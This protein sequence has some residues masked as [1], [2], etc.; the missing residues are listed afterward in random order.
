[1]LEAGLDANIAELTTDKTAADNSA[2]VYQVVKVTTQDPF[3]QV[4]NYLAHQSAGIVSKEQVESINTFAVEDYDVNTDIAYGDQR[5]VTEGSEHENTIYASGPYILI[6]K[7]DYEAQFLK[8]P[9]YMPSTDYE[10]RINEVIVKFIQDSESAL[11]ALRNSEIHILNG[12]AENRYDIVRDDD[13]LTLQQNES[14]AVSY[15]NFNMKGDREVTT[16]I[17]LRQAVLYSINQDEFIS[18]YQY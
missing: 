6:S 10:P 16:N 8:N 11:S 13:K 18:F 7:N 5:T 12:V 3:P 15:L 9:G 14:N 17:A 4:L 2:G 1:A